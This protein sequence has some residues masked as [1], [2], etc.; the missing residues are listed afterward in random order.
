MLDI[1]D[2]HRDAGTGPAELVQRLHADR[3]LQLEI[4]Q[5]HVDLPVRGDL[6]SLGEIER[7]GDAGA[8]ER[9]AHDGSVHLHGDGLVV[10]QQHFH[11]GIRPPAGD[12]GAAG[13]AFFRNFTPL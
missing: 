5:H 12:P 2:Q 3:V 9:P 4:E 7:D 6:Q 10:D 13:S 11:S 1:M 8:G